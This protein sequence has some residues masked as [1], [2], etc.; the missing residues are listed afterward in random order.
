MAKTIVDILVAKNI[1][2]LEDGYAIKKEAKE[3][4]SPLDEMLYGHGIAETDIAEAK[5]EITGFPIKY[6]GGTQIPFDVLRQ[7]PEESA[8]HYKMVPFGQ[9]EGYLNV[10]MLYPEDA[11]SQEAIKFIGARNNI[12]IQI[13]VITPTDFQSVL[14]EY[15]SLSG[16]VTKS[17]GEFEKEYEKLS[18]DIKARFENQF[19]KLRENPYDL[20]KTLGYPWFQELKNDKFR[21]YYLIYEQQ[22]IVLFVGVSAKNNQQTVINFIKNNLKILNRSK[23]N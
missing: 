13:F 8:R 22:V 4:K 12:P 18:P 6:L 1:L 15:K 5:S 9:E 23:K 7:I 21:V 3:K 2:S 19:N 16:E 17:L 11:D 10:G 14:N 20:G